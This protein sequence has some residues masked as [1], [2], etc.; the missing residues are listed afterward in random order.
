MIKRR[1]L[2]FLDKAA[3]IKV[4]I[5]AQS[6]QKNMGAIFGVNKNTL[7]LDIDRVK[8]TEKRNEL[9]ATF[10]RITN[11]QTKLKALRKQVDEA[12]KK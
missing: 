1:Y 6:L 3:H 2:L 9:R 4:E 7:S 12:M 11:D 8:D 5:K 10:S